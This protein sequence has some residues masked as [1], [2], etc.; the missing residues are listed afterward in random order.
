[1][2]NEWKRGETRAG[3]KRVREREERATF[4]AEEWWKN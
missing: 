1:M 4:T 2:N 3:R